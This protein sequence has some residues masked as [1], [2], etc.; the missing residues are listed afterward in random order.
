MAKTLLI[1]K[2]PN[3]HKMNK[4][5]LNKSGNATSRVTATKEMTLI[6]TN[7]FNNNKNIYQNHI[8]KQSL[9]EN[10]CRTACQLPCR[11]RWNLQEAS[12]PT[13]KTHTKNSYNSCSQNIINR[14][15]HHKSFA[16]NKQ[17]LWLMLWLLAT[18][19]LHVQSLEMTSKTHRG[20]TSSSPIRYSQL[21]STNGQ[22]TMSSNAKSLDDDDEFRPFIPKDPELISRNVFTPSGQFRVFQPIDTDLRAAVVVQSKNQHY[23]RNSMTMSQPLNTSPTTT[24]TPTSSPVTVASTI[25]TTPLYDKQQTHKNTKTHNSIRPN[26]R[27][28]YT[29]KDS[30]N[31]SQT[32]QQQQIEPKQQ[33]QQ[34]TLRKTHEIKY[35]H[36]EDH[37]H[38]NKQHHLHHHNTQ[39]K[40]IVDNNV[41]VDND[42]QR[43]EITK[44]DNNDL[45]SDLKSLEDLLVDYVTNFFEKGQYEPVPGLVVELHNNHNQTLPPTTN[46]K[47][48]HLNGKTR[49]VRQT[50]ATDAKVKIDLPR[51]MATGRLLFLTGL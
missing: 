46:I 38:K 3:E 9:N 49:M 7:K 51:T 22:M 4:K 45:T 13:L 27:M 41:V 20:T 6:L 30:S 44:Q 28:V 50:A 48:Q 5:N 16:L 23:G 26:D 36:I 31:L 1:A 17:H 32:K 24:Q 42:V 10:R 8:T 34:N 11:N 37:K 14:V 29:A 2:G 18:L 15:R 43:N 25:S 35:D 12:P 40:N 19:I 33:Q 39:N 47:E 21:L